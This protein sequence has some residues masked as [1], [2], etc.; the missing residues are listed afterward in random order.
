MKQLIENFLKKYPV[1]FVSIILFAIV[2]VVSYE[3][4]GIGQYANNIGNNLIMAIT[5]IISTIVI[6]RFFCKLFL[7]QKAIFIVRPPS[8]R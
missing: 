5:I 2:A 8:T 4:I 6:P 1:T 3:K 7:L